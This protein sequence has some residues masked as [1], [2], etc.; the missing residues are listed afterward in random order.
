M[1]VNIS[2]VAY[3]AERYKDMMWFL[4]EIIQETSEDVLWM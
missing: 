3:Q 2:K 1:E 4:K